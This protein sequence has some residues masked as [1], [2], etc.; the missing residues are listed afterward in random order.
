[1]S[2]F[3]EELINLFIRPA[4][5]TYNEYDLGIFIITQGH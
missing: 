3:Y 4:R 5:Q 2:G 1:M